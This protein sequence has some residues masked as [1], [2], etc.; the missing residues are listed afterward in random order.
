MSA[1]TDVIEVAIADLAPLVLKWAKALINKGQDPKAE[2][3]LMLDTAD[4]TVDAAET[5]K[6]GP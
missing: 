5:A 4:A 6:F 3:D 2:L 1:V